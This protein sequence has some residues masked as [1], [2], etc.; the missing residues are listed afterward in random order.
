MFIA[1]HL[2]FYRSVG[3]TWARYIALLTERKIGW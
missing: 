3:A 2:I 1:F